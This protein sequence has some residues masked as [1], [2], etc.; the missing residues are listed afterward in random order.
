MT[1]RETLDYLDSF[2]NY[3]KKSA[4]PYRQS[5]KL[6]RIRAFLSVIGNPQDSFKSVHVAGT[7]GKGSVCVFCANIFREAGYTAGLYTSP[8]LFDARERLRVL[9]PCPAQEDAPHPAQEEAPVRASARA[10]ACA[11][12]FD[13]MISPKEM[14][15]LA[16]R[17]KPAIDSFCRH[18]PHGPLSFFEVYTAFAFEFFR[19]KKVDV[20]VLE[21]GLGGRLDAT[22]V[23]KPLACAITSISL[24]HTD[25]LGTTLAEIA[26]EK[27]GIIKRASRGAMPVISAPQ[28]PVVL[29]VL[30]RRCRSRGADLFLAG[31]EIGFSLLPGKKGLQRF[32]VSGELGE[33]GELGI[34]LFGEHQA[35]NACVATGLAMAA[36][37]RGGMR[38]DASAVRR[39]LSVTRWPGRFEIINHRPLI[40]LDGAHNWDSARMLAR[41]VRRF[42][43]GKKVS[44]IIGVSRDKDLRGI[45]RALLPVARDFVATA[46]RS[47]RAFSPEEVAGCIRKECRGIPVEISRDIQGALERISGKRSAGFLVTGSLFVVG[48]A[49]ALLAQQRV[50]A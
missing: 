37:A 49:R 31:R 35:V 26:R 4:Y 48:E 43:P 27:A 40:V 20:A 16:G 32:S 3:E 6:A 41:A 9:R 24:D 30:N 42:L 25:K 45:C 10:R 11:Q 33:F 18:S 14:A 7:K 36:S 44:V 50:F 17:L 13:G 34:T 19:E 2:V 46:A 29:E 38:V 47:P 5:F 21:T 15:S 22:N 23:V 39:G 8:H 28:R 12:D 1:Y